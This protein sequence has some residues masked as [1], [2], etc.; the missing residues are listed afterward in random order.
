MDRGGRFNKA[1]KP[2]GNNKSRSDESNWRRPAVREDGK[3]NDQQ[4]PIISSGFSGE[5]VRIDPEAKFHENEQVEGV[6][7]VTDFD[8]V[9]QLHVRLGEFA[10]GPTDFF[11]ALWPVTLSNENIHFLASESYDVVPRANGTRYLLYVDLAGQIYLENMSQHIFRLDDDRSFQIISSDGRPV[12]DTVLDGIIT[13]EKCTDNGKLTFLIHDAFRCNGVD[14]VDLNIR[15]RINVIQ[16][17]IM[18]Q[19]LDKPME[20]DDKEPFNLDIVD[21]RDARSAEDFLSEGFEDLFKYSFRCLVFFPREKG[22]KCGTCYDVFQWSEKSSHT[23]TFR[24]KFPEYWRS[25]DLKR[26]ELHAVGAHRSEIYFATIELTKELRNLDGRIIE[27]RFADRQWIFVRQRND[28]HHPNGRN[29][30]FNKLKVLKSPITRQ[31]LVAA[32]EEFK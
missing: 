18:K 5:F 1:R 29:A 27:C 20:L 6:R 19:R 11:P 17:E 24:L 10:K 21:C 30:I 15:A 32:L 14:L 25:G 31:R 12:T 8:L 9:R 2:V 23:C 22:Y 4:Q 28:R 16:E 13:Q 26:A 7:L 3:K